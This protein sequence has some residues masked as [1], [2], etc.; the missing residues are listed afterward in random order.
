MAVD[1]KTLLEK[2]QIINL[3]ETED[4]TCPIC[5]EDYLENSSSELPRKLPCGHTLGTECL[6]LWASSRAN[7]SSVNCPICTKPI[8]YATGL[9]YIGYA[10]LEYAE[11]ALV[12]FFSQIARL[13]TAVDKT[14]GSRPFFMIFLMVIS[15]TPSLYFKNNLALV[16]CAILYVFMSGSTKNRLASHR[17]RDLSKLLLIVAF[18]V[19]AFLDTGLGRLIFYHAVFPFRSTLKNIYVQHDITIVVLTLGVVVALEDTRH[20]IGRMVLDAVE[21][22]VVDCELEALMDALGL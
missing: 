9:Q 22:C 18:L 16:P 21:H 5:Y 20:A 10:T 15:A 12:R 11:E 17:Y 3:S 13:Y 2:T 14:L 1:P 6:L 4:K 7:T 8:A 19:G